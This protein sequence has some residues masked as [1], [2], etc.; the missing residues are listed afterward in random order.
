MHNDEPILPRSN[1]Q[2]QSTGLCHISCF[3]AVAEQ[4]STELRRKL[5]LFLCIIRNV[6]L[7]GIFL[8]RASGMPKLRTFRQHSFRICRG[9]Y[10]K[11]Y[12][13]IAATIFCYAL[14]LTKSLK[15]RAPC[16]ACPPHY[17]VIVENGFWN[18]IYGINIFE[19]NSLLGFT[20]NLW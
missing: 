13:N 11:I 16:S 10:V 18:N 19:H 5:D 17:D 4:Q 15:T 8:F 3:F 7:R 9:I 6:D 14:G 2:N 12:N 1:R 20:I